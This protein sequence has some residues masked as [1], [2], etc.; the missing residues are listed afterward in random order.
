M[1]IFQLAIPSIILVVHSIK[2]VIA[3]PT[4]LTT[5]PLPP[6]RH[7][8]ISLLLLLPLPTSLTVAFRYFSLTARL[9]FF[10]LC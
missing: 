3:L 7:V 5:R 6:S 4:L 8:W 2:F 9:N 10:V 1:S